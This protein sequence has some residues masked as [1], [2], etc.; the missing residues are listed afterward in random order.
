MPIFFR[1]FSIFLYK[2]RQCVFFSFSPFALSIFINFIIREKN[3]SKNWL[4]CSIFIFPS[5]YKKFLILCL[6]PFHLPIF[7]RLYPLFYGGRI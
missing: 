3:Y 7:R 1:I 6:S 2:N 5:F 4:Y